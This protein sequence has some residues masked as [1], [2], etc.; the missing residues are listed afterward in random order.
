MEFALSLPRAAEADGSLEL[1]SLMALKVSGHGVD[2]AL[3]ITSVDCFAD[4]SL[5]LSGD[6]V[7]GVVCRLDIEAISPVRGN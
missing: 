2:Q 5:L 3:A 6:L 4:A 7:V 1:L